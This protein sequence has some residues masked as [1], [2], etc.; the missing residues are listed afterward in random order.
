MDKKQRLYANVIPELMKACSGKGEVTLAVKESIARKLSIPVIEVE[1]VA[2]FFPSLSIPPA[3]Y[4]VM[5]CKSLS[6]HM[7]RSAAIY[8]AIKKELKINKA[9]ASPGSEY[10]LT[11]VNCLGLCDKGPAMMVNRRT[12][13]NLTSENAV[14][15]LKELKGK[16]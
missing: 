5:L 16:R 12:F 4:Q 1:Q 15:A 6:C 9:G 11:L 13:T 7:E 8:R 3:K 14:S 2:T 10:S